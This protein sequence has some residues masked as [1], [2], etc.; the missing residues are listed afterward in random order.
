MEKSIF[1][2]TAKFKPTGDQPKAIEGIVSSISAGNK[3]QILMGVTGS[4][5]TF[6]M[7]NVI[8][9]MKRPALVLAPN[10]TLA[11]QL[12]T[13]LKE[14]FPENAVEF[15][16]SY[17][18]YYQPEAY[19]ASTDTYIA[20]DSAINDD[21]DK[22]RHA[23][24][25]SLFERPDTIIVSSVSCIYGMGSP[26]SYA[27]L[28]VQTQVGERVSRNAF[29]KRLIEIQYSRNDVILAR[30]AFRVRGDVVDILP[31]HQKDTLI[32]IEFFGDEVESISIVDQIKNKTLRTVESISIY[33]NSHYVTEK[34]DRQKVV[35]QIL[36]DLG[37]RL[38]ELKAE[39]KLV[40]AQR[41]EQRTM[42]DVELLEE[43]GFCPGI[44]NYSRYLTG[45]PPGHP[46]PTLLQYF[47]P[48]FLVIIDE[49]HITVP[50]VGAMYRGDRARKENLVNYGFRLPSALDNRPLKFDEFMDKAPN[51]LYVSATPGKFE[52]QEANDLIFEQVIRPTGLIDPLIEVRP[53]KDQVDD[54]YAEIQK[55]VKQK[56]RVLVTTL[57]KRMAEDLTS[58]YL[59]LG[60]KI[61][62]LHSDIDS[63][64]RTEL[65]RDLRK[66][67]F[68]VLV[69]INLLREG[70][71]LPEVSLVAILDADKEGFLRS[72]SSLIQ[73]VGRAARNA[74]GYVIFYADRI[75]DSMK[76]CIEETDRRRSIQIA[77]NEEHN[78]KPETI[79]KAMQPGLR[80][81]YGLSSDE[82]IRPNTK[83]TKILDEF[84]IDSIKSLEKLIQS[85]TK[86]MKKAAANLQFERAAELRDIVDALKDRLLVHSSET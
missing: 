27:N 55:A 32:R 75:T 84:N 35:K 20:K 83:V 60:V 4:G 78:I 12:F 13:E 77:Y 38:R 9:S 54:L 28:V 70:L 39:G 48:E 5:K 8:T 69:G 41:L 7:A 29:L 56:A 34:N 73:T 24:T 80:D 62:Y 63:L 47:P 14:F 22:M 19:I 85:K 49:S 74:D 16:I 2:L 3:H 44:E 65:L 57:T 58:Y 81:I 36:H 64:E 68:D 26:E 42:N 59:D 45:L 25:R 79:K 37:V 50:Q 30:G 53:A 15:F 72:Q 76:A 17:Y 31:S 86:E 11:A 46:P 6:T 71:D 43:L 61:K 23:A 21:I 51:L 18:D 1:T 82:H 67:E 40:E 66:G 10:K 52:L 33:P